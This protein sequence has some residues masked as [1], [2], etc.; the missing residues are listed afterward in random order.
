MQIKQESNIQHELLQHVLA[1]NPSV[2]F[3]ET[4]VQPPP[5]LTRSATQTLSNQFSGT[6]T[7][8][9]TLDYDGEKK[10]C[11]GET[12]SKSRSPSPVSSEQ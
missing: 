11:S 9:T 8:L 6:F 12:Y 5:S 3:P 7:N 1:Q 4:L 2:A 10:L